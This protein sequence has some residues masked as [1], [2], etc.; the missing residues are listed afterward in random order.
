MIQIELQEKKARRIRQRKRNAWLGTRDDCTCYSDCR[1][2]GKTREQSAS[3]RR[4][5]QNVW[6]EFKLTKDECSKI[7]T[8]SSF[9]GVQAICRRIGEDKPQWKK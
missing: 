1:I 6:H 5:A 3:E 2:M 7:H 4:H 8:W 9:N